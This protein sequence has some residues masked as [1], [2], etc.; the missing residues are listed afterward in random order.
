MDYTYGQNRDH[1]SLDN[2]VVNMYI[3]CLVSDVLPY[4]HK[5]GEHKLQ[6][7]N[8]ILQISMAIVLVFFSYFFGVKH[9]SL[10]IGS[11]NSYWS[12]SNNVSIL[13]YPPLISL[14]HAF[15]WYEI[16]AWYSSIQIHIERRLPCE[17]IFLWSKCLSFCSTWEVYSVFHDVNCNHCHAELKALVYIFLVVVILVLLF[18]KKSLFI[19]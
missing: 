4:C 18:T 9:C 13:I 5:W 8:C 3:G 10:G 6:V 14:F 7:L 15:T 17:G 1:I 19:F 12:W 16:M 11:T 2:I